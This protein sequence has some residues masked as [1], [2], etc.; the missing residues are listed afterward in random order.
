L[1]QIRRFWTRDN[2][3]Q[4]F[5]N[6]TDNDYGQSTA[7]LGGLANASLMAW[8]DLNADYT[9]DGVIVGQNNFQ[10][11]ITAAKKIRSSC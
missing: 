7:I 3:Y 8:I 1:I 10:L 5:L 4:I 6:L 2:E 9:G 11:R